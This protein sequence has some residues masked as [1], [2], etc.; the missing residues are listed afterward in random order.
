V[1]ENA[2][3]PQ[4]TVIYCIFGFLQILSWNSTVAYWTIAASN[5]CNSEYSTTLH[6]WSTKSL[7]NISGCMVLLFLTH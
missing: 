1:S 2:V 4:N 3:P 5:Y 7:L 6:F